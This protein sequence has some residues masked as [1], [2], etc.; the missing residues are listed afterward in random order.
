MSNIFFKELSNVVQFF[1]NFKAEKIQNSLESGAIADHFYNQTNSSILA[2]CEVRIK[3]TTAIQKELDTENSELH[4]ITSIDNEDLYLLII[5]SLSCFDFTIDLNIIKCIVFTKA[6]RELK[7]P[8]NTSDQTPYDTSDQTP[9]DTSNQT[10]YDTSDQTPYN[11]SDQTPYNTSDQTPYNTSDQDSTT[12]IQPSLNLKDLYIR[13]ITIGDGIYN[14][15]LNDLKLIYNP[16]CKQKNRSNGSNHIIL[17]HINELSTALRLIHSCLPSFKIFNYIHPAIK[18]HCELYPSDTPI[19]ELYNT[20]GDKSTDAALLNEAYQLR[21]K[22]ME[23]ININFFNKKVINI[24]EELVYFRNIET[25]LADVSAQFQAPEWQLTISKLLIRRIGQ[26]IDKIPQQ[27]KLIADITNFLQS[28][29]ISLI[30]TITDSSQLAPN[31]QQVFLKMEEFNSQSKYPSDRMVALAVSVA[32]DSITC[33]LNLLKERE[34]FALTSEEARTYFTSFLHAIKEIENG[35]QCI[36]DLHRRLSSVSTKNSNV[37]LNDYYEEKE[38]IHRLQQRIQKVQAFIETHTSFYNTIS[39]FEIKEVQGFLPRV[40]QCL[41]MISSSSSL[42]WELSNSGVNSYEQIFS[43]YQQEIEIIEKQLASILNIKIEEARS[44][45]EM[46]KIHELFS[47]IRSRVPIKQAMSEYQ[48]RLIKSIDIDISSIKS[49][50]FDTISKSVN[51]H[52]FM[53]KGYTNFISSVKYNLTILKNLEELIRKRD[54]VSDLGYHSLLNLRLSNNIWELDNDLAQFIGIPLDTIKK[55][56]KDTKYPATVL[57]TGFALAFLN[58]IFKSVNNHWE[59]AASQAKKIIATINRSINVND[60]IKECTQYIEGIGLSQRHLVNKQTLDSHQKLHQKIY[61]EISQAIYAWS[62]QVNE[63]KKGAQCYKVISNSIKQMSGPIFGIAPHDGLLKLSVTYPRELSTIL[64]EQRELHAMNVYPRTGL[65]DTDLFI[66]AA[67]RVHSYGMIFHRLIDTYYSNLKQGDLVVLASD[68]HKEVNELFLEGAQYAW[69]QEHHLAPFTRKLSST[70]SNFVTQIKDMKELTEEMD[71]LINLMHHSNVSQLLELRN[72]IQRKLD[73]LSIMAPDYIFTWLDNFKPKFNNVLI[74]HLNQ[75]V[76]EWTD[77]FTLLDPIEW[78]KEKELSEAGTPSRSLKKKYKLAPLHVKLIVTSYGTRLEPSLFISRKYWYNQINTVLDSILTIPPLQCHG[79]TTVQSSYA[80]FES[81][82]ENLYY[83]AITTIENKVAQVVHL[84]NKWENHRGLWNS[85]INLIIRKLDTSISNWTVFI[86]NML[87]G[88]ANMMNTIEKIAELGAYYVNQ[89]MSQKAVANKYHAM[90]MELISLFQSV[91]DKEI[92]KTL[93]SIIQTRNKLEECVVEYNVEQA[94]DFLCWQTELLDFY[95]KMKEKILMYQRGQD[96]LELQNVKFP[97]DWIYTQQLTSEVDIL[98]E[99]IA[100]K[101]SQIDLRKDELLRYVEEKSQ[102]L[103]LD[104]E[105][106]DAEYQNADLENG[107]RNPMEVKQEVDVH[108]TSVKKLW[109]VALK[110]NRSQKALKID[111]IRY[112]VLEV[113]CSDIE[114]LY[115]VWSLLYCYYEKIFTIDNTY[116]IEITPRQ[117]QC[118]IQLIEKDIN[119]LPSSIRTYTAF[120]VIMEIIRKYLLLNSIITELKSE[121]MSH[122]RHWS[123]LQKQLGRPEFVMST[124][125]LSDIYNANPIANPDPFRSVLKHAYGEQALANYIDT[126]RKYWEESLLNSTN[127]K[128]KVN[129]ICGWDNMFEQLNEHL[130]SLSGMKLSPYFKEFEILA[131]NWDSKLNQ[132]RCILEELMDVQRRWVYL[133]GI[134][135]GAQDIRTQ[136]LAESNQFD[137]TSRDFISIMPR[138]KQGI[139]LTILHFATTEKLENSVKRVSRDLSSIQRA[140]GAYLDSQRIAFPR[141]YFIGDDDLLELIGNGKFPLLVAKHFRKIFAGIT[142]VQV[143]N[144]TTIKS[145]LSPELEQVSL[146]SYQVNVE[147]QSVND[148]LL[149]LLTNIQLIL[150]KYIN[151]ALSTFETSNFELLKWISIYPNQIIVLVYQ[152]YWTREV[153][154]AISSGKC[155]SQVEQSV[156]NLIASLTQNAISETITAIDQIKNEQLITLAVYQRDVTRFLQEQNVNSIDNFNWLS[157][158]RCSMK[159]GAGEFDEVLIDIANA[160]FQ[161]SYEYL[162]VY[163][164]LVQTPLTDKCFLTLTQ[165]LHNRLGGSPSGEAGSGKTESVKALGAQLGRFV[166]V[167]NCDESFDLQAMGRIF[168]GLCQVGAWGCF[169]EFNRLEERILSAVS[170]QIQT[171][172]EGLKYKST[173]IELINNKITLHPEVGI[174]ITMNPGYA[175]RSNLPENI[176]QLFR[177]VMMSAPDRQ[178]IAEVMLFAQGFLNAESL[179]RKIVPL[180]ILCKDQLSSQSHY[181][182]GLRALKNVLKSA[183]KAKRKIQ[184]DSISELTES[185]I[186]Q[187][188]IIETVVPKLVGNDVLQFQSLLKDVFPDYTPSSEHFDNIQHYVLKHCNTHAYVPNQLW[189]SKITQLYQLMNVHHGIMLVGPNGC[190][191][192]SAWST[193]LYAISQLHDV[194][195][196]AYVIAPK[197]VSKLEL[198]GVLDPTTREWKDGIFTSILR[199]IVDN[200]KGDDQKTKMHW[201]IFDGDVDPEWVE[202]LNSVLDDN[203]LFTLPN[204]ERL[205]LP[206][207]VKILF[208]VSN[209]KYATLATISRCGMVWFSDSTLHCKEILSCNVATITTH[210]Y[211]IFNHP[212]ELFYERSSLRKEASGTNFTANTFTNEQKLLIS[213]QAKACNFVK[214]ILDSDFIPNLL[215]VVEQKYAS[216]SVMLF[217]PNQ[218]IVAI[219]SSFYSVIY[220]SYYDLDKTTEPVSDSILRNYLRNKLVLCVLW[221]LGSQLTLESRYSLATEIKFD[222]MPTESLLDVDV[223][224][225]TG[226]WVNLA[227]KLTT[228]NI[229]SDTIGYA[230][231]IVSTIDTIRHE[232]NISYWLQTGEPV[233]LCGPPGSGK[234]M[235]LTAI[236]KNSSEYEAVFLNFSNTTQ[237]D[238]IFKVIDQYMVCKSTLKGLVMTPI[239][240]KKLII[241]CDEINLPQP[242]KY[243]TQKVTQLLRQIAERKGFYRAKDNAWVNLERVQIIGACNPPSDPGR[244]P[245]TQRFMRHTPVLFV[246]FPSTQSLKVIYTSYLKAVLCQNYI[247]NQ[248][249]DKFVEVMVNFY[250]ASRA[251]FTPDIQ[252]HYIYS[253]RDLSRWVRAIY[254]GLATN[255]IKE[256]TV[257]QLLRLIVHEGLRLFQDKLTTLEE[258]EETDRMIDRSVSNEFTNIN[259]TEVLQRPILFS[260]MTTT[261]YSSVNT[262]DIRKEIQG[263]L[264]VFANEELDVQLVVFDSMV[265]NVLQ[266][267]RVLQQPL[268]HLLLVGASG[269]G[270]AVLTKFVVWKNGMVLFQV[271]T[272]SNYTIQHF[273]EDLRTVM[274]LAGLKGRPVC[275]LLN[276]SNIVSSGFLE[277]MNALLASGDVPGLFDGDE[278]P[279]LMSQIR[280]SI[281]QIKSK[282]NAD[283]SIEFV[284]DTIETELYKW[285]ISQVSRY[286]HVVFTMNPHTSDFNNRNA[287]SPALFNRCTII[288]LGDWSPESI[289]KVAM[290]LTQ[291]VDILATCPNQFTDSVEANAVVATVMCRIHQSVCH[292]AHKM[293]LRGKGTLLTPR[294]FL[295]FVDHFLAVYGEK[296]KMLHEY[297]LHLITGLDKL[298]STSSEVNKQKI[299]L[300]EKEKILAA[301]SQKAKEMLETIVED[302]G[303]A[304]KRKKLATELT[305][306]LESE[307]GIIETKKSDAEQK[308]SLAQPA[309]DDAQAALTSI[310]PEYLREI[311]AYAMPPV[312][313][314]KVLEAVAII[315]GEKRYDWDGIK[316]LIRRDDFISTVKDFKASSLALETKEMI[317]KKYMNDESFTYEA[318]QRASKAAGPLQKW[319]VAQIN[320]SE[321]HT[322]IEPLRDNIQQLTS[323]YEAKM[324]ELNKAQNEVE[325]SE[326]AIAKLTEDYQQYTSDIQSIKHEVAQVKQRCTRAFSLI[327]NFIAEKERWNEQISNLKFQKSNLLGDSLVAAAF[328]TYLGYFD[329]YYRKSV[330]IPEWQNILQSSNLLFRADMSLVEYL[331]NTEQRLHWAECKL[332]TD[333][334]CIENAVILERFRRYP[335]IIDP[336]GQITEFVLNKLKDKKVIK[337]S[338]IANNFQKDLEMAV[339]FGYPILIQDT[340]NYDP[341]INRL[342]SKESRRSSGHITVRIGPHEVDMSP[343]FTMLLT[344]RNNYHQ[345]PPDLCGRVTLVNFTLTP[346]SLQSQ[347][348]HHLLKHERPDTQEK[349][350]ELMKIQSEYVYQLRNLEEQ[351]LNSLAKSEGNFLDDDQLMN[352]LTKLKEESASIKNKMAESDTAFEDIRRIEATY[353]PVANTLSEIYFNFDKLAEL[354]YMYKFSLEFFFDCIDGALHSL[355]DSKAAN[356]RIEILHRNLFF[357]ISNRVR[358]GLFQQDHTPFMLNLCRLWT[359]LNPAQSI[360]DEDWDL[361]LNTDVVKS[362][363]EL[364]LPSGINVRELPVSSLTILYKLKTDSLCASLFES[365][366]DNCNWGTFLNS[367]DPYKDVPEVSMHESFNYYRKAFYKL[368]IVKALRPEHFII[369]T[370]Y[371]LCSLFD[372][373]EDGT[374]LNSSDAEFYSTGNQLSIA[375]VIATL[376]SHVAMLVVSSTGFDASHKVE[377][378]VHNMKRQLKTVAMGSSEGYD[379]ASKLVHLGVLNG[380]WIFLKN[381]HLATSL[382]VHIEKI[383]HQA[384]LDKRL[385]NNFRLFMSCEVSC[386]IPA[387]LLTCSTIIVYEPL[388]GIKANLLRILNNNYTLPSTPKEIPRLYF[389]AAWLHSIVTERQRYT[390]LGWSKKLEFSNVDFERMLQCILDWIKKFTNQDQSHIKPEEIPWQAIN[391]IVAQ[392]IYGGR[393]ENVFDQHI[394]DHLCNKYFNKD[395][396]SSTFCLTDYAITKDPSKA[397]HCNA[398]NIQEINQWITELSESQSPVWLGLPHTSSKLMNLEEANYVQRQYNVLKGHALKAPTNESTVNSYLSRVNQ[399]ID[400]LSNISLD[401]YSAIDPSHPIDVCLEQ[402]VMLGQSLLRLILNQ[403]S[404]VK[405]MH[406]IKSTNE[407]RQLVKDITQDHIPVSWN[408][409]RVPRSMGLS[410]WIEDLIVKLNQLNSLT[411]QDISTRTIFNLGLFFRPAAFL[412]AAKQMVS[413][414]NNW[415]LEQLNLSITLLKNFDNESAKSDTLFISGLHLI[416]ASLEDSNLQDAMQICIDPM[417]TNIT[418]NVQIAKF[419]WLLGSK[420]TVHM[421]TTALPLYLNTDRTDLLEHLPLQINPSLAPSSLYLRGT[422]VIA[423]HLNS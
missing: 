182:F 289:T 159:P 71:K 17:S 326:A 297:Q 266:I 18:E 410:Q 255:A 418:T 270:K 312:M 411:V 398:M 265:Q 111:V 404:Q 25:W 221:G 129:L 177:S 241:F 386:G 114:G 104:I 67:E 216:G 240:N 86:E 47:S 106:L 284:D 91:F 75:A 77:E 14:S 235:T 281:M 9:Y 369:S 360:M 261:C 46:F 296:R 53:S 225:E 334:L 205:G 300:I 417:K 39:K 239:S 203:R 62:Q 311:R 201:I 192:T 358:C 146:E 55:K 58:L 228:T 156:T 291:K 209:L 112:R 139:S 84:L 269:V 419:T 85:D 387:S 178:A 196:Q 346:S 345:Y 392:T 390:P 90:S 378:E 74:M 259:L 273:E 186:L 124:V 231:C 123:S 380:T 354:H 389:I 336:S 349:H 217:N 161:Y 366:K 183:G 340:E 95:N 19:T 283:K 115:N 181:D 232:S 309:L 211:P 324:E 140:L 214:D 198:Y 180:F 352:S 143:E 168:V 29:P 155:I 401:N 78:Q 21:M 147:N 323:V 202:N 137:R 100:H 227:D 2:L 30:L 319:V 108:Y 174:F 278:W 130:N 330:F 61:G 72:K 81:V 97:S 122:E 263:K 257:E 248:N 264:C 59:S 367:E 179:A 381:V 230:D 357:F 175:G 218:S 171:I 170:Q 158:M 299:S 356:E 82:S 405:S 420:D 399:W 315:L 65:E 364:D 70:V 34:I 126:I 320:Y 400:Q 316:A 132:I 287:T 166:L 54:V 407:T 222:N 279:K 150:K 38:I 37:I 275:F 328:L 64:Q 293:Q 210:A 308:L 421:P 45:K 15:L 382:L 388:P 24:Q 109:D 213:Y 321:I 220:N 89:E 385:H 409:Y 277:Y 368:I 116:L 16:L 341:V 68:S 197:A 310:K 63:L 298:E 396:F 93:E 101:I 276:E 69:D 343:S 375:T 1:F 290:E 219:I 51:I 244:V 258:Q 395:I 348:L 4:Y 125:K 391:R 251:R 199:R 362:N 325:T 160:T 107:T 43:E 413:R 193:L 98:E 236:L 397:L 131:L 92:K 120:S 83:R 80:L 288:W 194:D 355:P 144:Q 50:Y 243:G 423:Q 60:L 322:E 127:Y 422:C 233:I 274:R 408:Q 56:T 254:Q 105:K 204:G 134:F 185:Q 48:S 96:Q 141:F 49:A 167:F 13:T 157:C 110:I 33:I 406:L 102:A 372:Y 94:I 253:P 5:D 200:I 379:E 173:T 229:S 133:E 87:K 152:I 142:T 303:K 35:L 189:L 44:A 363:I 119:K 353:N 42:I 344:S 285:F 223:D 342:L 250:A 246:D 304:E 292:E 148:W 416:A 234:T 272:H 403:L 332:P 163:E 117:L 249:T 57:G 306:Q 76:K 208:E 333:M 376:K 361:L 11:T 238:I 195:A 271:S 176:K 282:A 295:D 318:A 370:N 414:T 22:C 415:P 164:K 10:P 154:M 307:K 247:L 66:S 394:I 215:A 153:S 7:T 237:S 149:M 294:H 212:T 317:K 313:V 36:T 262:D 28:I 12:I 128:G 190:G 31:I 350:Q 331:S 99:V 207:N 393:I 384:Y 3:N 118:D 226:K 145:I 347:C 359:K 40:N 27:Q 327:E 242:D 26:T 224:L 188:S 335:L 52:I 412:T 373:T 32:Q 184:N 286:L 151:Q 8:Y 6:I 165:A 402:E 329:E 20:L 172:Q 73:D 371:L 302:S 169:D 301:N 377:E 103:K 191:K 136:L 337:T 280:E 267:D 113:L 260:N 252:Q 314:K 138:H 206:F 338:F 305:I 374:K 187:R 79:D 41:N 121:A 88:S 135:G 268:S 351:L 23:D 245:L 365:F 256:Y 383:I 162:G 339:R